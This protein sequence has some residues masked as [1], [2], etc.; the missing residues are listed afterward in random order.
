MHGRFLKL[1]RKLPVDD[2]FPCH[3]P[4]KLVDFLFQRGA[5]LDEKYRRGSNRNEQGQNLFEGPQLLRARPRLVDGGDGGTERRPEPG[6]EPFADTVDLTVTGSSGKRDGI[7]IINDNPLAP[8]PRIFAGTI[9]LQTRA[10]HLAE[11]LGRRIRPPVRRMA[12]LFELDC[13]GAAALDRH[14]QM[15]L[16]S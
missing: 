2:S 5:L 6:V 8:G 4:R 14:W 12:E 13:Q 11:F 1:R 16:R 15:Q 7:Q 10:D 3:E 9:R